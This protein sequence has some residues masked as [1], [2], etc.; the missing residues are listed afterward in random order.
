LWI[1]LQKY[2]LNVWVLR[3][4]NKLNSHIIILLVL[5]KMHLQIWIGDYA[6]YVAESIWMM[7]V[8][9]YNKTILIDFGLVPFGT[10]PRIPHRK[11]YVLHQNCNASCMKRQKH[12]INCNADGYAH[13]DMW[14]RYGWFGVNSK[15]QLACHILF[16]FWRNRLSTGGWENN[17]VLKFE[18]RLLHI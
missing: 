4:K 5:F 7:N 17:S 2:I 8:D 14:F 16:A 3:K 15:S 13:T 1:W 18:F 10:H 12:L 11:L 9:T 6:G